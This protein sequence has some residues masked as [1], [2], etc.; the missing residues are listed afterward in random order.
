MG[1]GIRMGLKNNILHYLPIVEQALKVYF[2]NVYYR[3]LE[4]LNAPLQNMDI[5]WTL[6]PLFLTVIFIEFYF[7]RYSREEIGWNTAF[8]NS[9]VLI[10]ISVALAKHIYENSLIYDPMKI[11]VLVSL[12]LFGL[13]LS[14][15][16]YYH[17]LPKKIAF[18]ISSAIPINFVAFVAII[19]VYTS[20]IPID[21]ISASAF[22]GIL[23]VLLIIT[24]FIHLI[25]PKPSKPPIQIPLPFSGSGED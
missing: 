7:S 24:G 25:T 11:G 3:G 16:D 8:G 22:L 15:I 20:N 1:I 17:I 13:I 12:I 14:I 6:I 10:F 4:I 21:F 19:L 9:L 18:K 23:M 5:L 2:L